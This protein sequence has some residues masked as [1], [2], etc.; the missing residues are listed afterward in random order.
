MQ[1][2]AQRSLTFPGLSK[3]ASRRYKTFMID[4]ILAKESQLEVTL[5]PRAGFII[6]PQALH[7][8]PVLKGMSPRQEDMWT[9]DDMGLNFPDVHAGGILRSCQQFTPIHGFPACM[10]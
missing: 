9:Y 4:D 10:G 5:G 7:S 2:P 3:A 6:R 1:P 8:C